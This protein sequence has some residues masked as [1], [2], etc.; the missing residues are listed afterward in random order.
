MFRYSAKG[1]PTCHGID[2]ESHSGSLSDNIISS[3]EA[4]A[5]LFLWRIGGFPL[6]VLALHFDT[7]AELYDNVS[8]WNP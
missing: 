2:P 6:D 8:L 1:V 5:Q 3:T 7:L 4:L